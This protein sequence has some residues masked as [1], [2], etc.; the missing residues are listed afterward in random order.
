MRC[1]SCGN[2]VSKFDYVCIYCGTVLRMDSLERIPIFKRVEEEWTNPMPRWKRLIYVIINPSRAF[3]DIIHNRKK[4]GGNL[5]YLFSCIAFGLIGAAAFSHIQLPPLSIDPIIN[6]WLIFVHGFSVFLQFFLF[7]LIYYWFF[8]WIANKFYKWGANL[9]INLKT[10]L[11]IRYGEGKK[12]TEEEEEEE[13]AEG[14]QKLRAQIE[15][16][17]KYVGELPEYLT[18]QKSKKATIMRLAYM[19]MVIGLLISALVVLIGLPIVP[20]SDIDSAVQIL[21]SSPVWGIIDWIQVIILVG[22]IPIT[23]SIALRDIANAS[24]LRAYISCLLISLLIGLIF[25]FLRP[26]LTFKYLA[27]PPTP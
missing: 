3:W 23:M 11:K 12:E 5:V 1:P 14:E 6:S 2:D 4:I 22:W 13:E 16:E 9:S 27:I 10:R 21:A 19:P 8:Y 17:G 15:A 7:G 25:Y 26:T 20:A 24:T 18:A